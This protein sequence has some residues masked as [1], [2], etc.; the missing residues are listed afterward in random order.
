MAS[1]DFELQEAITAARSSPNNEH[2]VQALLGLIARRLRRR[3]EFSPDLRK[4]L[5]SAFDTASRV[6]PA[7]EAG[8]ELLRNLEIQ[9]HQ[10]GRPTAAD[11]VKIGRRVADLIEEG[12]TQGAAIRRVAKESRLT[13]YQ[14]RHRYRTLRSAEAEVER[15]PP[16]LRLPRRK[17]RSRE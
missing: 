15:E 10:R 16:R 13:L 3:G 7:S 8:A 14:V 9:R 12:S 1:F 11:H 6:Y 4:Y 2:A 5:V 17:A